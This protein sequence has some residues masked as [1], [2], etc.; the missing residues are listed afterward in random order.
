MINRQEA[1][2][3]I[4]FECSED[5]SSCTCL[6]YIKG[7]TRPVVVT[8]YLSECK[9]NTDPWNTMPRRMLRHKSLIQCARVA[10]GFS[11]I[12]D[13][14]EAKDIRKAKTKEIS[15]FTATA[16]PINPFA[17]TAT[18]QPTLEVVE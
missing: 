15:T 2:D 1:L 16:T 5:G 18:E 4:A 14:D 11:G 7:R 17:D 10:F 6:I 12:F 3:G 9:R 13:E 8:E